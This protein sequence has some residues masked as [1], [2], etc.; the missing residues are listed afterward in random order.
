MNK[1]SI[2]RL[3]VKRKT[4][5]LRQVKCKTIKARETNN[6]FTLKFLRAQRCLKWFARQ[7]VWQLKVND[8]QHEWVGIVLH[9]IDK[10]VNPFVFVKV[11]NNRLLFIL[12]TGNNV[13]GLTNNYIERSVIKYFCFDNELLTFF[14]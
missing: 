3:A 1:I 10:I 7:S 14:C 9:S 2:L 11:Y 8:C 5:L 6:K 4:T 13:R 12:I